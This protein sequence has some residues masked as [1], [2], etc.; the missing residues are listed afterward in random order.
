MN[1][2]WKAAIKQH[3]NDWIVWNEWGADRAHGKQDV[4]MKYLPGAINHEK[5]KLHNLEERVTGTAVSYLRW[6]IWVQHKNNTSKY[7][8]ISSPGRWSRLLNSLS[9]SAISKSHY[10]GHL[11]L[12]GKV[13]WH[14]AQKLHS[15]KSPNFCF[16]LFE[17]D[18]VNRNIK[19]NPQSLC[20]MIPFMCTWY[21]NTQCLTSLLVTS[22]LWLKPAPA[23]INTEE[24]KKAKEKTE[25]K[26]M[27]C[28]CKCYQ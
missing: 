9:S 3:Q 6:N 1:I 8:H 23:A 25:L 28:K 2:N 21:C 15:R 14:D 19:K 22:L 24:R 5:L 12:R 20:G 17:N 10:L 18:Q 16:S 7:F 4:A 11:I 13:T 27:L 26:E